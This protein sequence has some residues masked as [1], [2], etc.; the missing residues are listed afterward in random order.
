MKLSLA[1]SLATT[2]HA[3]PLDP[4]G[5]PDQFRR[6]IEAINAKPLP[7]GQPLALAVGKAVLADAKLRGRCEPKRMSL[8]RPEPVTLDGM[9]TALI[10]KGQIENGWLVSV[11]LEDCPPAD[12]IRVLL[13][14]AS[15]GVALQAFFAGQGESLAWP[16][17]SREVLGA[18]V[19]AVSQRLA[20]EDP[21][22]KPQGLT[23]T[24]SR[25][26]GTSPDFGPS[27]YGIRLKGSWNEAWTFEPCGHR[28]SVSIAFRTNGTG[29]AYWDI[30]TQGMVFVR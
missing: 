22:C 9:I 12:P 2:A 30:D 10:A 14:R 6:D 19:S 18:T 15:D 16:S 3:A 4:L 8:T 27:Q 11:K 13:L 25:I 20:R 17:L 24:G 5:D 26:T 21:A 29:G 7:D 23:P 28:V 1:L